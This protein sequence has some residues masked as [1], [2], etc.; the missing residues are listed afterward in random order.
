[1]KIIYC[2]VSIR[3]ELSCGR[4]WL[5]MVH[6][7]GCL[8]AMWCARGGG[9][10]AIVLGR[11]SGDTKCVYGNLFCCGQLEYEIRRCAVDG[12]R[13][14]FGSNQISIGIACDWLCERTHATV[15]VC[16]CVVKEECRRFRSPGENC[17][18]RT[19]LRLLTQLNA[20][21]YG[22]QCLF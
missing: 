22:W 19:N 14:Q 11:W 7:V 21:F 4:F 20:L 8:V 18:Y 6:A 12:D 16:M 10:G 1:M 15:C 17:S 3:A 13:G 2:T 5:E 9:G